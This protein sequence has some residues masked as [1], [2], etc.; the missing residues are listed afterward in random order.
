MD[1]SGVKMMFA[2]GYDCSQIVLS[3]VADELEITK[4]EA[5]GIAS[6]LGIGLCRGS[7]CGA[8]LGAVVALGIRYG[9]LTPGDMTSKS[10]V[11]SKREEFLKRFEEMNGRLLCEDLLQTKVNSLEEMIMKSA[12]GTYKNCPRYCVN[13]IAILKDML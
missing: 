13:A 3:E 5:F 1:E 8:A 9:N 2:Q 10:T 11:F 6:G 12:E 4:E 7:I